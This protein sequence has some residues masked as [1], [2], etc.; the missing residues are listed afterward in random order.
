MQEVLDTSPEATFPELRPAEGR[1]PLVSKA[2]GKKAPTMS[3][4]AMTAS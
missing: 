4:P 1:S 3:P 2:G